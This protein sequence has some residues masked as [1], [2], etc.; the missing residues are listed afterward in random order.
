M[1]D[2]Q[3]T[4]AAIL[5]LF[6]DNVTGQISPQDLR[7]FVVTLMN[8]EF[9]YEGDFWVEPDPRSHTTD[10][11]G[12]G[13]MMYSQTVETAVSFGNVLYMKV[14]GIW[15]LATAGASAKNF[16][17]GVAMDSY[18]SGA[19]NVQVL[20]KGLIIDSAY[21]VIF[22]NYKGRPIYLGSDTSI[23]SIDLSCTATYSKI[24]GMVCASDDSV[25]GGF[26]KYFFDPGWSV[27]GV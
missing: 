16:V 2:T 21:S 7:D 24:I 5:A 14:S 12:Y 4:R 11:T 22:S 10:K 18:I 15:S 23:G 17:L 3:R 13:W 1:A 9:K 8:S 6:A 27:V 25:A 20:R 26:D 19:S